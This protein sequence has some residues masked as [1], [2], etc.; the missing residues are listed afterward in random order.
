[1]LRLQNLDFSAARLSNGQQ[2][3]HVP[4]IGRDQGIDLGFPIGIA[5]AKSSSAAK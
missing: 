5:I 3:R 2:R 1:V 4:A